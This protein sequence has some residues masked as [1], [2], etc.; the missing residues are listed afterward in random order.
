MNQIKNNNNIDFSNFECLKD[1]IRK[2]IGSNSILKDILGIWSIIVYSTIIMQYI[3]KLFSI[4]Y[5][6]VL[7]SLQ[8]TFYLQNNIY[9]DS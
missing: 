8:S 2:S 3:S 7:Y 4:L 5:N 6:Y 1:Q 9:Y